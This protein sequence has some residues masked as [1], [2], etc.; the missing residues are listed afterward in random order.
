MMVS[1]IDR[2][3]EQTFI[4]GRTFFAPRVVGFHWFYRRHIVV[5]DMMYSPG[6]FRTNVNYVL[7][8]D[9]FTLDD[10]DALIYSAQTQHWDPRNSRAL[11]EEFARS[12]VSDLR[13]KSIIR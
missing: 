9:I 12:I 7:E 5:Y 1:L 4:Q 13:A 3:K 11:G 2:E 8:A 6:R 10:N